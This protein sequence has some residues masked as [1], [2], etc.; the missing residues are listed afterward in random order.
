MLSIPI[1]CSRII[2]KSST[3]SYQK[4]KSVTAN[5]NN[6]TEYQL[7][8][9]ELR[10]NQIQAHYHGSLSNFRI[11]SASS[12]NK[13]P[14]IPTCSITSDIFKVIVCRRAEK[15]KKQTNQSINQSKLN[16]WQQQAAESINSQNL[17]R[18]GR[19]WGGRNDRRG[20]PVRHGSGRRGRVHPLCY[21]RVMG[22]CSGVGRWRWL[23]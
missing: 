22:S 8:A 14:A 1:S 11:K 15:P 7:L 6:L 17:D 12:K 16:S 13:V 9:A 23:R 3:T 5:P 10:T 2:Q 21:C 18:K 19:G 20:D 4:S